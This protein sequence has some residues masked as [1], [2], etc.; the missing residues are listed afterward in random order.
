M[1]RITFIVIS[2]LLLL[3]AVACKHE[4]V[5]FP[6]DYVDVVLTSTNLPI[7]WIEV[8][9]RV[10]DRYKRVEARLKVI[11]NGKG[12]IN[13]ADTVAHPGQRID[14]EGYVA[15][16]YRGNSTFNDSPKKPYSIH[17]L[18]GRI[19]YGS[20]KAVKILGMGKDSNWALM[21]PY[22]DRSMMRDL[23][24]QELA[25]PWMEYTPQGRYCEVFVDG[26]YYGLYILCETV[27]G[28]KHRLNLD[29]PR[30]AGDA[31]TGDYLIEVDYDDDVHYLSRH[32][33]VDSAGKEL[34]DKFI[35]IQYKYPDF[36]DLNE[37]QLR[38]INSRFDKM[39]EALASPGYRD[40]DKGYRQ[41]IDVMSFIDYQLSMELGH[42]VDAYRKSCKLYKRRDGADGRFKAVVWDMNLAY[43]NCKLYNGW[44][45]QGW[46]YQYN[47]V[48]HAA[49]EP[50]LIPFWWQR[51]NADED[52][53]A[54]VR[55]RWAQYRTTNLTLDH[56]DAVIDS[57]AT[58]LTSHGAVDRNSRAWPRWG[59]YVW[60]NY[61]VS[62]NYADE[63]NYLKQWLHDRVAWMDQAL[64][65]AQ[66]KL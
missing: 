51:L 62:K 31:L 66:Q 32:H 33:P 19:K 57:L 38:Y 28:G 59:I 17:T 13:Y 22:S 1:S 65:F 48:L 18:D 9:G 42:N 2:C 46:I 24:A 10:I 21:A 34:A 44:S 61:Y 45:T 35:H 60:P 29:K 36:K 41:Y 50:Y 47:D 40:P 8:N 5:N 25:R 6:P 3:A 23:L 43:G 12:H 14:Y 64:G 27:T 53:Q 26:T 11:D 30:K 49:G 58:M 7:V 52:Y 16:R 56:I 4:P 55:E 39:E 63:V 54:M 20:K 37:N 15:L